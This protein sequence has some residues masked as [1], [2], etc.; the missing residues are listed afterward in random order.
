MT[1]VRSDRRG[2]R[3]RRF[4]LEARKQFL[5]LSPHEPT[6]QPTPVVVTVDP[7]LSFNGGELVGAT[8]TV[9]EIQYTGGPPVE[10]IVTR[11]YTSTDNFATNRVLYG[12]YTGPL[13]VPAE[14]NDLEIRPET[15]VVDIE[16]ST[17]YVGTASGII[18]DGEEPLP[19]PPQPTE[20][21]W[22][23]VARVASA[24]NEATRY[25]LQ[26]RWLGAGVPVEMEWLNDPIADFGAPETYEH[27]WRQALENGELWDHYASDGETE[28]SRI[29]DSP[30]GQA[31]HL[32]QRYK[33][34]VDGPFSAT[35]LD[36]KQGPLGVVTPPATQA[37][38][39][40]ANLNPIENAAQGRAGMSGGQRITFSERAESDPSCIIAFPDIYGMII[41]DDGGQTFRTPSQ[42]GLLA[43]FIVGAAVDPADE[44]VIIF[45][46][47]RVFFDEMTG[48]GGIFRTADKGKTFTRTQLRS[49]MNARRVNRARM[50][51]Y[52][53]PNKASQT[54]TTRRW[55]G[56]LPQVDNGAWQ[57]VE[58]TNGGQSWANIV[59][60]AF[61]TYG[62]VTD[63]VAHPSVPG[64]FYLCAQ[65]GVWRTI[66][67]GRNWTDITLLVAPAYIKGGV[68]MAL[69]VDINPQAGS[70]ATTELYVSIGC[71]GANTN[72]G[73]TGIYRS[74]NGGGSATKLTVPSN[75]NRLYVATN[76][77][78]QW[79]AVGSR[80]MYLV[81]RGQPLQRTLNGGSTWTTPSVSG[82][83]T[84]HEQLGGGIADPNNGNANPQFDTTLLP[85]PTNP[86]EVW[87]TTA[88]WVWRSTDAGLTFQ[89]AGD[90][91]E[92]FNW[93]I[94]HAGIAFCEGNISG[95]EN[96]VLL[97]GTDFGFYVGIFDPNK[98]IDEFPF[99]CHFC[100]INY[101]LPN[102]QDR[103]S[104]NIVTYCSDS[105][106][107]IRATC[108]YSSG[109]LASSAWLHTDVALPGGYNANPALS[110]WTASSVIDGYPSN[111]KWHRQNSA[112]CYT[113]SGRFTNAKVNNNWTGF[114]G[115]GTFLD[116]HYAD[117][118]VIYI[119]NGTSIRRSE[120]A[121][122]TVTDFVTP[123]WTPTF[124]DSRQSTVKA[125]PVDDR[126][127]YMIGPAE[128][129]GTAKDL[130][131]YD[132]NT[133][134]WTDFGIIER[135]RADYPGFPADILAGVFGIAIDP[136]DR[137]TVAVAI[138][139]ISYGA[140][141]ITYNANDAV[142]VWEDITKNLQRIG[143]IKLKFHPTN[144]DLW[145]GAIGGGT[146]VYPHPDPHPDPT[147][148]TGLLVQN[149][150][151]AEAA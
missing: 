93:Q 108:G 137:N 19:V 28:F 2:R 15:T 114:Q 62:H 52:D 136:Q 133:S 110:D 87:A 92:F 3:S 42:R 32:R 96:R 10:P 113:S 109:G 145:G 23:V 38:W 95:A 4:P 130:R 116:A 81:R 11:L 142:P 140:V 101:T 115:G 17:V 84:A 131:R 63:F 79:A 147:W 54:P 120:N 57:I 33:L 97:G 70:I 78:G 83:P 5:T 50:F 16:G 148:T 13:T 73:G 21:D 74:T 138:R 43:P 94:G 102:G 76:S 105:L 80:V 111:G 48:E 58:S 24:P 31:L 141:Y 100:R 89:P 41:S 132:G 134:T 56:A 69:S 139:A 85:H 51:A 71:I 45:A 1:T 106:S 67:Y 144:G 82:I 124:V 112:I 98:A 99:T 77:S 86:N 25:V 61:N 9:L 36:K 75:P 49:T 64:C 18:S 126:V 88:S 30:A 149:V 34:H 22:E 72:T 66:D 46:G 35:S 123:G 90:Y 150:E 29:N 107:H 91:I 37:M 6:P 39:H 104:S 55:L 40:T 117:N 7:V 47:C 8:L 53:K 122:A 59:T 129:S 121:G 12:T 119:W 44:N 26:Y 151:L 135:F 146:W 14:W 103:D 125:D 65:R 127:I 20:D 143:G 68:N 27:L 60:L 128:A 118:D